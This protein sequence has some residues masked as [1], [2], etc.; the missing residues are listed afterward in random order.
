[1]LSKQN[2][3]VYIKNITYKCSKKWEQ[4]LCTIHV[5][6]ITLLLLLHLLLR[7][8]LLITVLIYISC[9]CM[10]SCSVVSD[11]CNPMSCSLPGC[12]VHGNTGQKITT[13]EYQG[14][15]PFPSPEDLPDPGIKP[16]SPAL[17]AD[18][19]P[20]EPPE[21]LSLYLRSIYCMCRLHSSSFC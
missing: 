19:L 9:A 10:L 14:G 4:L 1:M 20:S 13:Q 8:N 2:Q 11:F 18:S 17:P 7:T 5:S 12:S 15:L 21:K 6:V 3:I 16:G